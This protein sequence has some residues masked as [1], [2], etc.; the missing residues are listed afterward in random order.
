MFRP[1]AAQ[2]LIPSCLFCLRRKQPNEKGRKEKK[3]QEKRKKGNKTNEKGKT[4]KGDWDVG[5]AGSKG[6][7]GN[8][9]GHAN[10]EIVKWT[11]IRGSFYRSLV[12]VRMSPPP[13]TR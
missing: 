3:R 1:L 4:T 8:K 5:N 10:E 13:P 7:F 11:K 2:Q 12:S 9:L 6:N